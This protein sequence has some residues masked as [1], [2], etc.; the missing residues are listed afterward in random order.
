[1]STKKKV[2]IL[3]VDEQPANLAVLE[4]VLAELDEVLVC[5]TSGEQ[6]LRRVSL[7]MLLENMEHKA[8]VACG[9]P[10]G[11]L[12]RAFDPQL[13]FLDIGLP[14]M[15]GHELARSMRAAPGMEQLMPVALTGWGTR[16][17]V[18]QSQAAG[19][20]MHLTKPVDCGALNTVFGAMA[21]ER[22]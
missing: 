1:M 5:V 19:F 8:R 3:L 12:A 14:G 20:D 6:A 15:S 16:E 4:A 10:S 22:A 11:P 17:D 13:A 2:N 7:A 9:G 21:K 18:A